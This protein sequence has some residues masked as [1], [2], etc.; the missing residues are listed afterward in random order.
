MTPTLRTPL[1]NMVKKFDVF[2]AYMCTCNRQAVLIKARGLS[3]VDE[4]RAQ[5]TATDANLWPQPCLLSN[6]IFIR[7]AARVNCSNPNIL[8]SGSSDVAE[9][10][11][12]SLQAS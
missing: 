2:A 9:L 3:P 6:D 1:Y 8:S 11:I 7:M 5:S 4:T 12:Q 10:E